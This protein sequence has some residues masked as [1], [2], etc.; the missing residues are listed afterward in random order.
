MMLRRLGAF[1]AALIVMGGILGSGIFLNPSIVAAATHSPAL[2]TFVWISGGAIALLG[3]MLFAELAARRPESGGLYAYLRDAY[4]PAVGFVYGW[5]LLLVAQSGGMAAGA[6]TFALYVA[7]ELHLPISTGALAALVIGAFTAINCLGV[8]QGALAQHVFTALNVVAIV[9]V[10]VLSLM[11]TGSAGHT[12]VMAPLPPSAIAGGLGVAL[13]A[14]LFAYDGW[15]VSSFVSGEYREPARALPRG[16]YIGI[17]AVIAL[18]LIANAAFVHG[19]G[20]AGLAGTQTPASDLAS[21]V[22]GSGAA[23]AI[24]ALIALATM[25]TLSNQILVSPRI[26]H[27]MAA[28]GTFFRALA[29]VDARTHVPVV[30]IVVQGVTAAVVAFSNQYATILNY[31]ES[32]DFVFF[33]LAAVALLI[34]RR[35]DASA[36]APNTAFA[37]PGYPYTTILFLI[38]AIGVVIDVAVTATHDTLIGL[39]IM[40]AGVPVYF[41]WASRRREQSPTA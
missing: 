27:Q 22:L 41:F 2:A 33:A 38:M 16:L 10:L 21:Q 37:M 25:S 36:G 6:V 15:H 1:D 32:V 39:G 8:R 13:I 5:T 7:P 12:N 40:L 20:F 18:Y 17:S 35:R 23:R 30:A 29:Y 11:S 34:F 3:A 24:T 9:A 4:H 14:V 28:D 31:V 19:L 26:Y